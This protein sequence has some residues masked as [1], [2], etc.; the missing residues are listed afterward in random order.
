[1]AGQR[2]TDLEALIAE[3]VA[4]P[5]QIAGL[6]KA[7][8]A[9]HQLE[10]TRTFLAHGEVTVL[11]DQRGDWSARFDLTR[12]KANC[13]IDERWIANQTE[14]EAFEVE[15]QT[16]FLLLSQQL[17]QLRKRLSA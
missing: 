5:K 14:A 8:T 1:M 15:L 2:L 10:N 6:A 4:T 11:V 12:Y 7:I 3:E 9:W 17:G 16:A 13:A